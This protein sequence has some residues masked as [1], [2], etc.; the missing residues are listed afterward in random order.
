LTAGRS[1]AKVDLF[2]L[3]GTGRLSLRAEPGG[4]SVGTPDGSSLV[5]RSDG[6]AWIVTRSGDSVRWHLR[7][8]EPRQSGFALSE[9]T[10]GTEAGSTTPLDVFAPRRSVRYLQLAD[11]RL[12]R[13]VP[14]SPREAGVE[15]AGWE[16]EGAYMIARPAAAG[17]EIALTP[18]SAGLADL[19]PMLI[20]FGAEV[21][22]GVA[23]LRG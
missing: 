19:E 1:D 16:S 12:F 21:L 18:A 10:G 20:L 6:D 7:R 15:L 14:A 5:A 9:G 17:W 2:A 23:S 11:G 3:A 4:F 8:S 22:D 13:V